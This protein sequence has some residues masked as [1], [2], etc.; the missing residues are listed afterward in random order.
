MI[1]YNILAIDDEVHILE[2]LKYNLEA[3]G[4]AVFCGENV[5]EGMKILAREEIDIILLD[6]MLPD[7]D[8]IT[9]LTNL[10]KSE[11]K[12]IPVLLVTAKTD[13][14]DKILGLELGAD[15]YICKPFSV[16][17][18][19]ARVKVIS[20]RCKK[21]DTE[22]QNS[23]QNAIIFKNLSMDLESH[24]VSVDGKNLELSLKEFEL[25]KIL[26]KNPG[27]AFTRETLLD[28]VWG[29]DYQGETRTVDV[30]IRYIRGKLEE[31]GIDGWIE[32]V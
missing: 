2:L 1:K 10:K 14:I 16:R 31:C 24:K 30:H 32:T 15:D 17:E 13:E 19:I 11:Y 4:F 12:D 8:G 7:M 20:R 29:Y 23:P 22:S 28:K 3:N 9:A 26:I 6:V 5:A 18:L 27:R 21:Y 25:L